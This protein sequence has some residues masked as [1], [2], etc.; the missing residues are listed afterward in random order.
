MSAVALPCMRLLPE[1]ASG[2][3]A[4]GRL[5]AATGEVSA[6]ADGSDIE[7]GGLEIR[8]AARNRCAGTWP[9]RVAIR[10]PGVPAG[11]AG[12]FCWNAGGS[13]RVARGSWSAAGADPAG[14]AAARSRSAIAAPRGIGLVRRSRSSMLGPVLIV[15]AAEL[16]G[17]VD[18][19]TAAIAAD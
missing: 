1:L 11:G 12:A 3:L 16:A 13:G 15:I 7:P 14:A 6:G 9:R 5:P 4:P 18:P 8:W 19:D 10:S 2:M 17:R